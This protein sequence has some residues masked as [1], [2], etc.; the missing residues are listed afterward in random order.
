[1]VGVRVGADLFGG[2]DHATNKA[3]RD[4]ASDVREIPGLVQSGELFHGQF[5]EIFA[6]FT[7]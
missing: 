1:M 7:E 4:T 2:R 3:A 5:G 6:V